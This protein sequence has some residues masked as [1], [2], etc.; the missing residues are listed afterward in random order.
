MN[1]TGVD[2]IVYGADCGVT[3]STAATMEEN[4]EAFK[5]TA[6]ESTRATTVHSKKPLREARRIAYAQ[7][8]ARSERVEDTEKS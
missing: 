1:M 2:H 8:I 6:L 3:C 5:A 4:R 7:R